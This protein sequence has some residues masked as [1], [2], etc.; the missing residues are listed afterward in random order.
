ME[1]KEEALLALLESLT[2]GKTVIDWITVFIQNLV[3]IF[4]FYKLRLNFDPSGIFTLI[5]HFFVAI[6][7][8]IDDYVPSFYNPH[9]WLVWFSLFYFT[10]EMK[11]MQALLT[12]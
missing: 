8:L 2:L 7:R 1:D 11:I 9:F 12:E 3:I 10:V 6:I 5:L 4:V